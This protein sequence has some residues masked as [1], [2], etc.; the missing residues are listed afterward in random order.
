M[1]GEKFCLSWNEF[2]TNISVAFRELRKTG[3][4]F[5]V[6][7]VCEDDQMEAHKVILSACSPFF[8]SVLRRNP[9]AHPLLYLKG[10][11][12]TDLQAILNFMYHGEVTVLQEDLTS[13]LGVAEE[14]RVKGLTS[15]PKMKPT[16]EPS[17]SDEKSSLPS[18]AP[19]HQA[20]DSETSVEA[21]PDTGNPLQRSLVPVLQY[22]GSEAEAGSSGGLAPQQEVLPPG[23]PGDMRPADLLQFVIPHAA[24]EGEGGRLGFLCAI[25]L[26][27]KHV[28][29][30]N[31]R[32]HVESKHFK[33]HFVYKC[34]I[35]GGIKNSKQD[36]YACKSEH[37]R[38]MKMEGNF[39]Q[40]I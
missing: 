11:K 24:L 22:D 38:I 30:A 3:D 31:V 40:N 16:S 13:F 14:L 27:F 34:E 8:R 2:E 18:K 7:L 28:Y 1:S 33:G 17:A 25:C 23:L 39:S 5:D 36:L 32:N 35:C 21:I 29:K 9:H 10:V 37:N 19:P 6:T 15:E 20:P 12:Q 26:Q 4:F